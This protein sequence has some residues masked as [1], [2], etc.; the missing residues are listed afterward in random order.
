MITQ[1]INKYKPRYT[2]NVIIHPGTA[3]YYE[4][5]KMDK[6]QYAKY[7][8]SLPFKAGDLV[9]NKY[10]QKHINPERDVQRV[11]AIEEV[12]HFVKDWGH[13]EESGPACVTLENR[14]GMESPYKACAGLYVK[15]EGE[16]PN[17]WKDNADTGNQQVPTSE[18][19]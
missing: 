4:R 9:I 10:Y 5:H 11:K 14:P 3:S 12:H 1:E 8:A 18:A 2:P 19:T 17:I 7:I 6:V 15:W 16:T 13:S